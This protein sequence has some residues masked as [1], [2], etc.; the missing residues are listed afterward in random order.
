MNKE[1]SL[2][3]EELSREIVYDLINLHAISSDTELSRIENAI[4]FVAKRIRKSLFPTEIEQ[5]SNSFQPAGYLDELAK[6]A[7]ATK[8][9]HWLPGMLP[10]HPDNYPNFWVQRVG[11]E[12]TARNGL[13]PDFDDKA[14]MLLAMELVRTKFFDESKLW[15]GRVEIHQDHRQIFMLMQPFHDQDGFLEYRF[16]VSGSSEIETIVKALEM[17]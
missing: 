4:A 12:R 14:T 15:N 11:E 7:M 5:P 10:K 16:I 3:I 17:A 9:W 1:N 2:E 6:R 13:I 8:N